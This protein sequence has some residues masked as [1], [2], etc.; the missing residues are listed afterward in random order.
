MEGRDLSILKYL[1]E[2]SNREAEVDILGEW[3]E[4]DHPW[5]QRRWVKFRNMEAGGGKE[6]RAGS[7]AGRLAAR[8]AGSA[9]NSDLSSV[10]SHKTGG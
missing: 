9:R 4:I 7:D 2:Y 10:T 3:G 6:E 5:F 8:M 1:W